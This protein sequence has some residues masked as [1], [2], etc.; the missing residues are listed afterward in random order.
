MIVQIII[1]IFVIILNYNIATTPSTSCKLCNYY[2]CLTCVLGTATPITL[3]CNS[4]SNGYYVDSSNKLCMPCYY[5][6]ETCSGTAASCQSCIGTS[7]TLISSHVV[8]YSA[9]SCPSCTSVPNC[10]YCTSS[11]IC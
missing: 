11:T 5:P 6:C 10:K 9:G 8:Y 3:D 1:S 4:C 7:S 2:K